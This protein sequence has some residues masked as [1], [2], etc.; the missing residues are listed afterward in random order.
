MMGDSETGLHL[1]RSGIDLIESTGS[2]FLFSWLY[3]CLAECHALAGN[4]EEAVI[5]AEKFLDVRYFGDRWKEQQACRALALA[6]ALEPHPDWEQID[7]HIAESLRLAEGK[8]ARPD[9]A[10]TCFRYATLL[11]DK[12]DRNQAQDSLQ[13]ATDLFQEMDMTWWL[14]EAKTWLAE[15]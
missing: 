3:G 5:A 4:A 15:R 2:R 14:R 8:N 6:A 7:G 13:R 9:L 11:R 10:I 1:L 12:G